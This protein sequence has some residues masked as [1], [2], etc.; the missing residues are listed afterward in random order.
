M[1]NPPKLVVT[2]SVQD[3]PGSGTP[4]TYKIKINYSGAD[5][6]AVTTLGVW[7]PPGF[8]Y[9]TS[10][11][12]NLDNA[13][14]LGTPKMYTNESRAAY[15]SGE[16]IVWTFNNYPFSGNAPAS[17]SAFPG[18]NL[19]DAPDLVSTVTLQFDGPEGASPSAVSWVDTNLNLGGGVTYAWDADKQVFQILSA[20]GNTTV[21]AYTV[22]N[23]LR[24][25][26]EAIQGDYYATGNSLMT[27]S[28]DD[29]YHIRD[30]WVSADHSSS[31]AVPQESS[32]G[33]GDGVPSNGEVQAA[34]LYW[35]SW[36][37]ESNKFTVPPLGPDTCS[38]FTNWDRSGASPYLDTAWGGDG[39]VFQ[40]H[41]RTAISANYTN[42]TLKNGVVDL[43]P[44]AQG[45]VTVSWD[46]GVSLVAAG[47]ADACRNFNNWSRN[48]SPNVWSLDATSNYFTGHFNTGYSRDLTLN[49]DRNL[50]GYNPGQVSCL[51]EAMGTKPFSC[52]RVL[53]RLSQLRPMVSPDAQRLERPLPTTSVGSL[54]PETIETSRTVSRSNCSLRRHGHPFL[55]PMVINTSGGGLTASTLS[56]YDGSSWTTQVCSVRG[57]SAVR[58]TSR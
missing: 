57:A 25:M 24:Q 54:T 41:L 53:R 49:S 31:N 38:N 45:L 35:T 43:N 51:L 29:N 22:K 28:H 12:N 11:S 44:Y 48:P 34:Y 15:K 4:G 46:Q 6:L 2:G 27:N 19:S 9:H 23:Q 20:A 32:P 37:H 39:D 33:A 17:Q 10:G 56:L 42:L 16:K 36:F 47:F 52:V 8:T 1:G 18:V 55:G 13:L 3:L 21:E 50:A 14:G 58:S 30:H 5:P 40:G 7:L 26:A